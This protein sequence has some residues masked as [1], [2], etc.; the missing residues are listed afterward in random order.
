MRSA[1]VVLPGQRVTCALTYDEPMSASVNTL[2]V[3]RRADQFITVGIRGNELVPIDQCPTPAGAGPDC[4][5]ATFS[6]PA[7]MPTEATLRVR[8]YGA[9]GATALGRLSLGGAV[10]YAQLDETFDALGATQRASGGRFT[11]TAG[12]QFEL[13][14]RVRLGA[15]Y[16]S[17]ARYDVDR[18]VA[19]PAGPE[20]FETSQRTPSS[21]AAGISG[22]WHDPAHRA[23]ATGVS[24]LAESLNEILLRDADENHVTAGIGVGDRVRLDAAFDRSENTTRA[25]VALSSTF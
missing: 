12:S 15:S 11:W 9:A 25:S 1:I 5:F 3:P 14:P 13:S 16:Q 20:R 6:A 19:M 17:G 22:W 24:G 18:V 10:Q 2:T 7:I 21:Y 4:F 23:R 8:R